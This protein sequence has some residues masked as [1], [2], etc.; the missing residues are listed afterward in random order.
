[1]HTPLS[2]KNVSGCLPCP[3]HPSVVF[4]AEGWN[5]H[6][7]WMAQTPYPPFN[8]EPYRDYYEL[9]C[10]H[11]SDD[12]VH[13]NT[14]PNNPIEEL[15]KEE[16]DAHNYYSDPHLVLRDGKLDLYYRFTYLKD[17][18]LID[19]KTVLLKRTSSDGFR[20]SEREIVADLRKP[21]DVAIWGE[22]IISQAIVWNN[23][24]CRCYYV[25]RS[26][27]L[28]KRK[29]LC[30]TS[31]NGKE[32][33]PYLEVELMGRELDPWHIDVQY[34]DGKFQMIVYD[35]D[36]LVWFDSEDGLCFH[37]VSE[38]LGPSPNRYDFYSDGLYR[39]CSVKTADGIFV[40]FSARRKK[41]TY[42]G[43]LHSYDRHIFKPINGIS[44]M[45]WVP[46]VWKPLLK[47]LWKRNS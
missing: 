44:L 33:Q 28:S 12:G 30:T 2:I 24:I 8:I 15:T 42:I 20:W 4:V 10:V 1:M 16:I 29:I 45:K 39:A 7:Y 5:G 21:E 3:W 32:W 23:G 35:M 18:Q 25:D 46:T 40:Y 9:P 22:Q 34:Y 43:L 27:Y 36:R 17:K 38:I 41:N 31:V 11:Y 6:K 14:I 26:S 13:W 37:F 19:N 47:S